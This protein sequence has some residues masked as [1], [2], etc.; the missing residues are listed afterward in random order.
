MVQKVKDFLVKMN[1]E[2]F[3][4]PLLRDPKTGL[5]SVSFTMLF[6]SFNVVLVGLLGKLSGFFGG[7]DIQ[8]ALY[9]N[10]ITASLYFGRTL[11]A[12]NKTVNND[13]ETK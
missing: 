6:I 2:G 8:Q 5:G 4:L 13:E 10:M 3:P 11:S 1:K 7:V 9:W 12:N